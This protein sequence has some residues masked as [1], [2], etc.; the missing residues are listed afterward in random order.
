MVIATGASLGLGVA[1]AKGFAEPDVRVVLA[2]RR[3]DNLEQTAASS[4]PLA[5]RA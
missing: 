1:F 3:A 4:T 2:A 5:N